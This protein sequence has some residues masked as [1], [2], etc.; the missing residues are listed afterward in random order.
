MNHTDLLR[1]NM[2]LLHKVMPLLRVEG[3]I[4]SYGFGKEVL[5]GLPPESIDTQ[6]E[7]IDTLMKPIRELKQSGRW[8]A[9]VFEQIVLQEL[10]AIDRLVLPERLIQ[11]LLEYEEIGHLLL[12]GRRIAVLCRSTHGIY[13][14]EAHLKQRYGKLLGMIVLNQGGGKFTL[15][16]SDDF[17]ARPLDPLYKALN[18]RDILV[19]S[20]NGLEN[21]WGGSTNIGGSPRETG[22]ALSDLEVFREV[23]RIYGE[24]LSL[25]SR[26]NAFVAGLFRTKPEKGE[27]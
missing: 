27:S 11:Q 9:A 24:P 7:R 25:W 14:V 16:Q 3:I 18:R 12:R 6:K 1:D 15:R 4:D 21:N 8:G 19:S 5:S 20:Q 13:E 22:S 2:H 23:G 26:I 17:L 10:E